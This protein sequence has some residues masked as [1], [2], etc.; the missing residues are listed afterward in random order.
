MSSKDLF[1]WVMKVSHVLVIVTM[2]IGLVPMTAISPTAA[3]AAPAPAQ[4]SPDAQT[5]GAPFVQGYSEPQAAPAPKTVAKPL[6]LPPSTINVSLLTDRYDLSITGCNASD[7]YAHCSV[8]EAIG[9]ANVAGGN[10]AINLLSGTYQL[11]LT[12]AHDQ[13]NAHNE[14]TLSANITVQGTGVGGTTIQQSSIVG[15]RVMLVGPSATCVISGTTITGGH[16]INSLTFGAA[17]PGGGIYNAGTLT[18]INSAVTGN[19]AGDG[20]STGP[21]VFPPGADG[22]GIYN[23]AS[24]LPNAV[25][26]LTL[27][28][29]AVSGNLAGN[30]ASNAPGGPGGRGG[31]IFNNGGH[32]SISQGSVIGGNSGGTGGHGASGQPAG[33][34]GGGGGIYNYA[35][36]GGPVGSL[37]VDSSSFAANQAGAGGPQDNNSTGTGGAGGDG[38]AIYNDGGSVSLTNSDVGAVANSAGQGGYGDNLVHHG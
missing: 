36:P 14:V 18:L 38:G 20:V 16:G 26:A 11:T 8:R 30:G 29:T 12:G 24:A 15:N 2:A 33:D 3:E 25:G 19:R 35:V 34:G 37:T 32:V 23:D 27:V 7:S 4:V 22:G 6:S 17:E 5:A 1:K 13:D 28:N 9:V 31:G 10:W 21:G